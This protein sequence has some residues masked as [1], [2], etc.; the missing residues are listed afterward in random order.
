MI[1]PSQ[2]SRRKNM[3]FRQLFD[4]DSCTY[5][6]LLGSTG[7]KEAV[8]IDPV[9][10]HL[11]DYL[12][13]LRRLGLRLKYSIETHVHADHI[14]ASGRLR[15]QTG[16][17]TA[18]SRLCGAMGAD[19][20]L[21]DG[22]VLGFAGGEQINVLATPGHTPGS[23]S[24]LWRDRLFTGDTLLINGCGRTDF[25]GGDPGALYDSITERLFALPADTLVYPGHDYHGRRVSC[26]GQE[27]AINPR[28]AGKTREQFIEIMH[29]LDLP[30]PRRIDEAVPRNRLCGLHEEEIRQG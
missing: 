13:L 16:A 21:T 29:R 4:P 2:S 10:G 25:Q 15:Q 27:R 26:I 17:E 18:V 19:H 1:R 11:E 22:R 28:L 7:M 12:D 23:S 9:D 5:T 14:T 24:F 20:Q 8:L 30:K 3:I 6:Y